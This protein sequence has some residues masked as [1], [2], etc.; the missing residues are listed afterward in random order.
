MNVNR[1]M[2]AALVA[3]AA[4]SLYLLL[5]YQVVLP[6]LR[7][8]AWAGVIGIVTFPLYRRLHARLHQ[9]D[10]LAASIMTPLVI[11]V[12]VIPVLA[13][14]FFL[15]Q[16]AAQAFQS[17]SQGMLAAPLTL[18]HLESYPLVKSLLVKLKPFL[19]TL[20]ISA[21][22]AMQY[23]AGQATAFVV[24]S[25]TA[26]LKNLLPVTVQAFVLVFVLFFI[27]KDGARFRRRL[28]DIFVHPGGHLQELVDSVANVI[29]AVI[30]GV[31]LACFVQGVLG[32]I[33]YWLVGLPSPALLGV[34]TAI[35]ALVP[36]IG[37]ALIW[38]PGAIYLFFKAGALKAFFLV[39]WGL[40]VVVSADN[41]IRPFFISGRGHISFLVVVLGLL[42][43]LAAFGFIGIIAGPILLSLFLEVL[44]IYLKRTAANG[45][46][47]DGES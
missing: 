22:Q 12:L 32:G 24:G 27:Y 35:S 42:G 44:E 8:L 28:L 6:Y 31:F 47:S 13:L 38:V 17:L 10:W 3:F 7:P 16:E 18:Q 1:N 4:L 2:F 14:V 23:A 26:I 15:A 41:L 45:V 20:G 19:D 37:T 5:V 34:M 9:R 36:G 30:L 39:G 11:L 25:S 29:H 33:G 46:E 21:R 43:G 40:V